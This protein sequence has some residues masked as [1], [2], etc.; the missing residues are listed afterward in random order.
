MQDI[1][2]FGLELNVTASVTFPQGT[3]ITAFSNDGDPLDSPDLETAD[4]AIGPNGD[5]ITWTRPQLI[6]ISTNVIPQSDDDLNLTTILD[7]N[8]IEK[9]KTSARDV[10]S[11]VA[12]YPNG[13]VITLSEGK[14]VTAPVVQSGTSEGKAKT[15]RFAFKFGKMVRKNPTGS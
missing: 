7:A 6:E 5:T 2:I 14:M 8:R 9:G 13:M 10:I 1:S 3:T 11:I 12:T 4:M 15:K